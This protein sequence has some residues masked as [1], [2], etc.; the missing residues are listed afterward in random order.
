MKLGVNRGGAAVKSSSEPCLQPPPSA[1]AADSALSAFVA[2][3]LT[4][5]MEK[6]PSSDAVVRQLAELRRVHPRP[7]LELTL[8]RGSVYRAPS[9]GYALLPRRF[10]AAPS[11]KRLRA[12][13]FPEPATEP[14]AVDGSS[15]EAPAPGGGIRAGASPPIPADATDSLP[16][17]A[18]PLRHGPNRERYAAAGPQGDR[19]L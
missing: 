4:T 11:I 17:Q 5:E 8:P 2:S 16:G 19:A 1:G 7:G 18:W 14:S 15:R 9:I 10:D 3:L 12:V 13:A 6:R